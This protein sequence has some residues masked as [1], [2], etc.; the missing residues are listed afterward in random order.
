LSSGSAPGASEDTAASS[1]ICSRESEPDLKAIQ[2]DEMAEE[3]PDEE[4]LLADGRS[5]VGS[6][7]DA[8][9]ALGAV[10]AFTT[11]PVGRGS[12]SSKTTTPGWS[13]TRP[14]VLWRPISIRRHSAMGVQC[15]SP[16]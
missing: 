4:G 12:S 9:L 2:L 10:G 16:V 11:E 8:T 14:M 3:L 5:W 15:G 1:T 6:P 13:V 7:E